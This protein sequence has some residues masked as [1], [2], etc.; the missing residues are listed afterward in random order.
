MKVAKHLLF[1]PKINFH[2]L[3]NR[4]WWVGWK[5]KQTKKI[6]L[7]LFFLL[8]YNI[9]TWGISL[10]TYLWSIVQISSFTMSIL[11][12]ILWTF[13]WRHLKCEERLRFE[14][15]YLSCS[16]PFLF[17]KTIVSDSPQNKKCGR[18]IWGLK[19]DDILKRILKIVNRLVIRSRITYAVLTLQTVGCTTVDSKA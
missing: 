6:K 12:Q 8:Y 1:T 15:T 4:K 14:L 9:N 7:S 5:K 3:S 16:Y 17:S 2:K 10:L 19:G 18:G 13:F 11:K